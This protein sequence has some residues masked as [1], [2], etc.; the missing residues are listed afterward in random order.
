MPN[1]LIE[2]AG[3]RC[4]WHA[5]VIADRPLPIPQLDA[6]AATVRAKAEEIAQANEE[7]P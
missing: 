5:E 4:H 1:P 2:A 7:E 6:A 3:A